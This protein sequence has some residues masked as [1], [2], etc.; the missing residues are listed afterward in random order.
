MSVRT[1]ART[2]VILGEF[3]KPFFFNQ[4]KLQVPYLSREFQKLR[5]LLIHQILY[6]IQLCICVSKL[7][8]Q[9]SDLPFVCFKAFQVGFCFL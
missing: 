2:F 4:S 7:L 8:F 1:V 6:M 9:V 5:P 3:A